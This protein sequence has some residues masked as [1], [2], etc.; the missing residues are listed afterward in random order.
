MVKVPSVGISL[1]FSLH[2]TG[3]SVWK[4]KDT[5]VKAILIT[6]YQG[7][8]V[9]AWLITVL[10]DLDCLA[11]TVPLG[12]ST[13]RL[14]FL[15]FPAV[16]F[17]RKLLRIAHIYGV[18]IYTHLLRAHSQSFNS[19][20]SC[21]FGGDDFQTLSSVIRLFSTANIK[22]SRLIGKINLVL[23]FYYLFRMQYKICWCF[24]GETRIICIQNF[25]ARWEACV[26]SNLVLSS[27]PKVLKVWSAHDDKHRV[28][29]NFQKWEHWNY[30]FSECFQSCFSELPNISSYLWSEM[31]QQ[32]VARTTQY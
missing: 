18:R 17:G 6:S 3:V 7:Y 11:E 24:K 5:E 15:P 9:S 16:L 12:I 27:S 26:R 8:T 29:F 22:V 30:P 4:R 32:Y 31:K 23:I 1:M 14:L 19:R 21:K 13:I 10:V 28:K 25:T 2:Q 20:D